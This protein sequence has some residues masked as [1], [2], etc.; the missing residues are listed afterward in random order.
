MTPIVLKLNSKWHQYLLMIPIGKLF[1]LTKW[2]STCLWCHSSLF[3]LVVSFCVSFLLLMHFRPASLTKDRLLASTLVHSVKK[4][5][6]FRSIFDHI[7]LPQASKST[8]ES[9]IQHIVS[10]VHHVK[11]MCS[12]YTFNSSI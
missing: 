4:E 11:G 5:Q 8:S 1:H 2:F 3:K 9:F 7:K 6:E 12:I 10:L